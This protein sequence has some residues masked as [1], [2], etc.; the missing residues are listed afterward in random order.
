MFLHNPRK[1]CQKQIYD[2]LKDDFKDYLY[3]PGITRPYKYNMVNDDEI[4][5]TT[6]P[7]KVLVFT[8]LVRGNSLE[9]IQH[10]DDE[11]AL[12]EVKSFLGRRLHIAREQF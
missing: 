7:S 2:A 1:Y 12:T 10:D 6:Y 9:I 5:V 4:E 8:L 3:S 11:L